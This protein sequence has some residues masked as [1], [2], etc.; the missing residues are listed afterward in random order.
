MRAGSQAIVIITADAARDAGIQFYRAPNNVI[1]SDGIDGAI[2][3]RFIRS[4][5][6]LPSFDLLWTNEDRRWK[7]PTLVENGNPFGNDESEDESAIT[8]RQQA[9]DTER[10]YEA[11]PT[12]I[13]CGSA[14]RPNVVLTARRDPVSQENESAH[15]DVVTRTF[16]ESSEDEE[17]APVHSGFPD[18]FFTQTAAIDGMEHFDTDYDGSEEESS[19]VQR[20]VKRNVEPALVWRRPR[21]TNPKSRQQSRRVTP[22]PKRS[23]ADRKGPGESTETLRERR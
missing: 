6:L 20:V 11:E 23:R 4:I 1:L 15:N 8:T 17:E 12:N 21:Q 9:S 14:S 2:P 5:R 3:P 19:P 10:N 13:A 7:V 22:E 16:G 18:G